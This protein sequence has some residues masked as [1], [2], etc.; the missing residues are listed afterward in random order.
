MG[1]T[2]PRV[3]V[4]VEELVLTGFPAEQAPRIAAAL[5]QELARL[6]CERGAPDSLAGGGAVPSLP[7]SPVRAP[8]GAA[9]ERVGERVAGSVYGA[10][11]R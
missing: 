8:A 1:V 7:A 6:L 4:H 9:P 5:Q 11:G 10:L 3:E 2:G